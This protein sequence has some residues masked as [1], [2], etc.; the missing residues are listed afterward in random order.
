MTM[1]IHGLGDV[2]DFKGS[3]YNTGSPSVPWCNGSHA[4]LKMKCR[5]ACRFE[6]D[7]DYPEEGMQMDED[8]I[9]AEVYAKALIYI[10]KEHFENYSDG[11][12]L[13]AAENSRHGWRLVAVV[14]QEEQ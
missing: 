9:A 5:K 2:L 13:E 6:S 10:N 8:V 7:R 11:D 4:S 1:R 3:R 14:R 12:I